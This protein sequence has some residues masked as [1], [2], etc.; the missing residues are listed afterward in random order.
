MLDGSLDVTVF[1]MSF[2]QLLVSLTSISFV[3]SFL[4]E[5]QELIQKFDGLLKVAK[6]LL[7]VTNLLIAFGL[8]I[9]IFGFLGRNQAFLEELESLVEFI[10]L[11]E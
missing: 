3:A 11:L 9:S 2:C 6:F 5:L 7:N 10:L 4:T 8:F 1:G